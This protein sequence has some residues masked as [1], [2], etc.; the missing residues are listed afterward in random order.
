MTVVSQFDRSS[1]SQLSSRRRG[2]T[3]NERVYHELKRMIATAELPAGA[4]LTIRHISAKLNVSRTPVVE[5]IRRLE[6]DGLVNAAPKWGASV[7][8][9]SWDE[10]AE[11]NHIRRGLEVEAAEMFLKRATD[12][13]KRKLVKL[14]EL[15]D[16]CATENSERSAEVDIELHLHVARAT[17]FPRLYELIENSNIEKTAI[18][19]SLA[20][21]AQS[22]VNRDLSLVKGIHQL[23]VKALL[24]RDPQAA[25]AEM[26]RHL[27]KALQVIAGFRGGAETECGSP[28][29]GF[30]P[31]SEEH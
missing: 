2:Q 18:L 30:A 15:F 24:G 28:D 11:A 13:D 19:G 16:R 26:W 20:K 25:R 6:G 21:R 4:P 29:W 9:W 3:A 14:N 8:E 31:S 1:S 27:D 23:L 7:K 22:G 17:R 12:E 5:A 10:I